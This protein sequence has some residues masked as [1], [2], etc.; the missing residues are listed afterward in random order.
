MET[1]QLRLVQCICIELW[2]FSSLGQPL[3]LHGILHSTRK[4]AIARIVVITRKD[5][6]RKNIFSDH[7]TGNERY[8]L[9]GPRPVPRLQ[10]QIVRL[11]VLLDL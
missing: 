11:A 2:L 1:I 7:F 3:Q 10:L 4:D 8:H 9:F 6:S 5:A